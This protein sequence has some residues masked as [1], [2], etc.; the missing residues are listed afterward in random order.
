MDTQNRFFIGG[1]WVASRGAENLPVI[2]PATGETITSVSLGNRED[3]D[4]AVQAAH[5][6]FPEWSALPPAKRAGYLD[7]IADAIDSRRD[8]IAELITLDVGVP[9]EFCKAVQVGWTIQYFRDAADAARTLDFEEPYNETATVY[10]V[11]TGVVGAITP[12]NFPLMQTAAKISPALAAGCTVVLKPSEIAPLSILL[13]GDIAR[14]VG[15]PAGV[16][17][18]VVGTG[19]EAGEALVTH[20]KVG[21]V[22][23]TGSPRTGTRVMS[24]ASETMKRITFELGGKSASLVLPGADLEAAVRAT[25]A[26]CYLNSGQKCVA[27]TRLLVPKEHLAEA[28]RI[29]VEAARASAV[30]D[31]SNPANAIGPLV[32]ELQL[33]RV[34]G[35]IERAV[36]SGARLLTG[37]SEAPEGQAGGYY[38]QP[39][40][41][42]DVTRDMPLAQEEVFGPV[43]AILAYDTIAE[44]IEIANDSAYG[45]GGAVWAGTREE[46]IEAARQIRT[47]QVAVNGAI[48]TPDLP[49]GGFKMSGIGREGGR[50]ALEEYLEMQTIF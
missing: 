43:L 16:L 13:L 24:L 31:P 12:W 32:S 14:G 27:V 41:F 26:D 19:P 11:P 6:A 50:Y 29:A 9:I 8:E 46:G 30:G 47:G 42:T 44:G 2:N 34:R 49:F 21:A 36:A 37:G 4:S 33:E 10:K 7:A 1:E 25:V 5:S 40:V 23:F 17:N 22:S 38:V 18:V 45:L 48:P 3:I 35:H 39:T 28:E 15:L 20:P